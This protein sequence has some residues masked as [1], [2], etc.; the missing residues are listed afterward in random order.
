MLKNHKNDYL[1]DLTSNNIQNQYDHHIIVAP[2][3]DED[4]EN[5]TEAQIF[6]VPIKANAINGLEKNS[7]ILLNRLTSYW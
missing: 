1:L 2:I 4:W 5:L 7:N 3:S 6:E